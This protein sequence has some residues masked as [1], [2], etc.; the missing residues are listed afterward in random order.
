MIY[1]FIVLIGAL[2]FLAY[3]GIMFNAVPGTLDERFGTLE[4]LPDNLGTWTYDTESEEGAALAAAG[5]RL[6]IR[7][8]LESSGL[9]ARK[10]YL[11]KQVRVRDL[12]TNEII[13]VRPE[14][15]MVRRRR[16]QQDHVSG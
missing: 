16:K 11:I 14:Q 8:L 13:E 4:K 15:R 10:Q 7:H 2:G 5:K 3:L 1:L 12:A 6:E 9:L